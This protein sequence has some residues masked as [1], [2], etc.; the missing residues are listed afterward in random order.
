MGLVAVARG[1]FAR[2]LGAFLQ[3]PL[4]REIG[5]VRAG[6]IALL[7][8]PIAAIEARDHADAPHAPGR[9]KRHYATV[10]PL[11]LDARA[12][13]GDEAL[14]AFGAPLSGA[15][16]TLNLSA[17]GD[18]KEAAANLFAMLRALDRADVRTIA[19]MAV[20]SDGLGEAINDRLQRAVVRE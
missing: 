18:L 19:V 11:R 6:P 9:L 13:A 15:A 3:E 17:A 10:K 7:K 2:D 16:V 5:G 1:D 14:L 12:V 4:D 20:P 8:S